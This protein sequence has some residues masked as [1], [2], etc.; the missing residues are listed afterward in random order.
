MAVVRPLIIDG[1]G[2]LIEM[3]DAQIAAVKLRAKY[4]YIK[5]P[6]VILQVVGSNGN[7][8]TINDTRLQAGD[9]S[10]S[11]SAY[12]TEATTAEPST[13][14]VGWSRVNEYYEAV[15]QPHNGFDNARYPLYYDADGN[16]RP[17]KVQDMK[18]TFIYDAITDMKDEMYYV[19]TAK[20][21][22]GWIKVSDTVIFEDTGA[23]TSKY[24]ADGI[25]ED[26]DQPYTRAQFWLL[27]QN[28]TTAPASVLPVKVDTTDNNNIVEFDRSDFDE[29]LEILMRWCAVNET[30][31]RNRY[32]WNGAGVDR[33]AC[34][35]DRLNGTGNYQQR[36]VNGDDYRAQEFPDGSFVRI[37]TYYLRSR[38]E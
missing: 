3:T 16:L 9:A 27:A 1:S 31:Y 21:L 35:D 17:M 33:G 32:S 24:S 11:V 25:T 6:S 28:P 37:N 20:T 15:T 2:D 34:W 12:P 13:V 5:N 14:T 36:F 22:A 29:E 10:T 30:G 4:L 7:L 19:H 18:D 26:K 38:L 8:G 23:D